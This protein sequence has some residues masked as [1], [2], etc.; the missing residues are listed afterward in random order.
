MSPEAQR[1][2]IAEALGWKWIGSFSRADAIAAMGPE[3]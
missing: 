1:I 2:A 3:I